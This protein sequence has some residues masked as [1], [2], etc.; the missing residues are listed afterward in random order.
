MGAAAAHRAQR[1]FRSFLLKLD[2]WAAK[3]GQVG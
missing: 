2:Q 1:R 3:L